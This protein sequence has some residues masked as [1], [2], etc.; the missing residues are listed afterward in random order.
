MMDPG[1]LRKGKKWKNHAQYSEKKEKHDLISPALFL[2]SLLC[3]KEE[4]GD[5]HC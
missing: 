5:F 4:T 2:Y 3:I 1:D